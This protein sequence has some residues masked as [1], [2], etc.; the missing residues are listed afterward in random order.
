MSASP[1]LKPCQSETPRTDAAEKAFKE[2]TQNQPDNLWRSMAEGDMEPAKDWVAKA[3][4]HNWEFARILE[5]ELNTR[6]TPE[7]APELLINPPSD[8]PYKDWTDEQRLI[9]AVQVAEQQLERQGASSRAE[10]KTDL[11]TLHALV[12]HAKSFQ[13]TPSACRKAAEEIIELPIMQPTLKI[14]AIEQILTRHF[15]Q[16]KGM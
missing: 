15:N 12:K 2:Y 6:H 7:P 1:E 16:T 5:R 10:R 14:I 8:K 13:P 4:P 3:P 11:F 9:Y